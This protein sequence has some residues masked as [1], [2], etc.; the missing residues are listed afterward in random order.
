MDTHSGT[1]RAENL[2][3]AVI[4]WFSWLHLQW[5]KSGYKRDHFVSLSPF[6]PLR[7]KVVL[8]FNLK[9]FFI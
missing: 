7:S 6:C 5:R 1:T 2:S 4:P 3:I 9:V 8:Q